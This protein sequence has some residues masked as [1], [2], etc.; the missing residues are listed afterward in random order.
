[1]P[2]IPISDLPQS[3][4]LSGAEIFPIV[5]GGTTRQISASAINGGVNSVVTGPNATVGGG[6]NNTASGNCSSVGGGLNNA[7]S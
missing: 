7:A 2:V 6:I 1:M 3:T 5:Q 4:P